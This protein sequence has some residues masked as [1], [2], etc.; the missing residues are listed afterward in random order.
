MADAI[1]P[2][3][4]NGQINGRGQRKTGPSTTPVPPR[5]GT[6]ARTEV[7]DPPATDA[8]AELSAL[9]ER[10]AALAAELGDQAEREAGIDQ[11]AF[12]AGYRLGFAAGRDVG[13]GQAEA[14]MQQAWTALAAT[15]RGWADQ[16]RFT[17]LED[18]RGHD[19]QQTGR[20]RGRDRHPLPDRQ[21]HTCGG[22]IS[23]APRE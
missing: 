23:G 13:R 5:D 11:A 21:C 20:L 10:A 18:R 8:C 17:E 16:P 4:A 22:R 3:P 14:D 9:I 15:V 19:P 1:S 7:D 12:A 2:L 6:P